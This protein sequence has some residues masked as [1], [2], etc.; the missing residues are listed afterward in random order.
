MLLQTILEWEQNTGE[1]LKESIQRY[2]LDGS[3]KHGNYHSLKYRIGSTWKILPVSTDQCDPGYWT[4]LNLQRQMIS[5]DIS[6]I[7]STDR[8]IKYKL[9]SFSVQLTNQCISVKCFTNCR[10]LDITVSSVLDTY[11]IIISSLK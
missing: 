6:G 10:M 9:E 11:Y 3:T 1:T 5:N 2:S 7:Y 8:T 4:N